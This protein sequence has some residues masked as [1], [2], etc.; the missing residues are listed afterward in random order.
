MSIP[1]GGE[2]KKALKNLL[3]QNTYLDEVISS[4]ESVIL[5]SF[6]RKKE[7]DD[8]ERLVLILLLNNKISV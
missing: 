5:R 7:I 8:S 4:G 2:N 3:A 6:L 1:F